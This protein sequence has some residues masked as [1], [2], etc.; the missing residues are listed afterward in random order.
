MQMEQTRMRRA[1][2]LIVLLAAAAGA[3]DAKFVR[4]PA[5]SQINFV[6]ESRLLD[7]H[8]FWEKWDAEITLEP[9]AW[10]KASVR[11]VIDAKSVNTREPRRDT[12][13]RS[14]DFFHADSFPQITFTSR[15]VNR[16]TDEKIN[17]T[18]DL[19]IRGVT[20]PVT[21]PAT[22]VFWDDKARM[23][24][25]KGQFTIVRSEYGVSYNST[26]NPIKD[27]VAVNFDISFRAA[28]K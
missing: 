28:A 8:G 19:T 15:I 4:D 9:Q 11:I 27:E 13:L 18:G 3:Q 12:H 21:I 22:L 25:V 6:A 1:I 5:H 16:L 24:R 23:G 20:K 7:A 2:G 10:E 26:M 14:R 17:F